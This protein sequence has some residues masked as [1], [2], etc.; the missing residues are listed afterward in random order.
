MSMATCPSSPTRTTRPLRA[1][2]ALALT[3]APAPARAAPDEPVTAP[4]GPSPARA[5][6]SERD[7]AYERAVQAEAAGDDAVAAAGYARAYDLTPPAETGPRLLFLRA[8]VAAHLRVP[9]DSPAALLHLC[10]ARELLRGHLRD[11]SD[12]LAAER[13]D[14]AAIDGRIAA[15]DDPDCTLLAPPPAASPSPSPAPPTSSPPDPIAAPRPEAAPDARP[16]PAPPR[17]L[18][19]PLQIAG[20]LGL[21][22]SAASFALMGAGIVLADRASERGR[23]ACWHAEAGCDVTSGQLLDI[24]ADG[25]RADTFVRVGAALGALA[26]I[27]GVTLL[28]VGTRLA[29]RPRLAPGP[30]AALIVHF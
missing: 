3:L 8:G 19:R 21:G 28:L 10:Q 6:P 13:A 11:T 4:V 5:G 14:L 26:A 12:T 27:A 23:D 30:G 16:A 2:L 18:A 25:H 24:V 7:L 17:R 22:V 15:S 1:A 29:R 20:G 9:P